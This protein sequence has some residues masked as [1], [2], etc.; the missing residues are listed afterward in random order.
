MTGYCATWPEV[1]EQEQRRRPGPRG[2]SV[3]EA[4][5]TS[6]TR[7]VLLK[8]LV[9]HRTDA[10]GDRRHHRRGHPADLTDRGRCAR[11]AGRPMTTSTLRAGRAGHDRD[12][13]HREVRRSWSRRPIP[14]CRFQNRPGVLDCHPEQL[15]RG[16]N[17]AAIRGAT[18]AKQSLV[19]KAPLEREPGH[20]QSEAPHSVH[21]WIHRIH[22]Q[23]VLIAQ[24]SADVF[25]P[26]SGYCNGPGCSRP[27]SR[28]VA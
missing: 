8:G 11:A 6:V 3:R 25:L 2:L 26:S 21:G 17:P 12:R 27:T 13:V 24:D 22:G 9:H 15:T 1:P 7:P 28:F 4:G 18:F 16:T 19:R 10:A 23:V 20:M 14:A 5:H